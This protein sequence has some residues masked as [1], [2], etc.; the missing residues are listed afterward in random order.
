MESHKTVMEWK[1]HL[2]KSYIFICSFQM[3]RKTGAQFQNV[4]KAYFKD[5]P[6][7]KQG[8]NKILSKLTKQHTQKK[9]YKQNC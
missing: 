9:V 4:T 8:T 5:K 7:L 2:H 6:S 1:L 3:I